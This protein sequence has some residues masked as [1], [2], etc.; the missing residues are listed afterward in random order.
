MTQVGK[1]PDK[2]RAKLNEP[3]TVKEAILRSLGAGATMRQA[4]AM[5][6]VTRQ[7]LYNWM[8]T[9]EEFKLDVEAVEAE[10]IHGI[11][12]DIITVDDWKARKWFVEQRDDDYRKGPIQ[13]QPQAATA[14]VPKLPEGVT[15]DAI[16]R[17]AEQDE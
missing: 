7:T 12:R 3:I 16:R 5:A 1:N 8:A 17:A 15:A 4:A 11:V 9:D 13:H 2:V 14:E 10:L 6:R